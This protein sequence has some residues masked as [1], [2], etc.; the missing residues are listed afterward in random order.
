MMIKEFIVTLY[1]VMY[2]RQLKT[3]YSSVS[4]ACFTTSLFF[5][6]LIMEGVVLKEI[7]SHTRVI[8][9]QPRIMGP[10][11]FSILSFIIYLMLF[12]VFKVEPA[13]D[14]GYSISKETT[15]KIWI[16]YII[17]ILLFFILPVVRKVIFKL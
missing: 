7:V 10:I 1:K 3:R 4:M 6:F 12:K 14:F 13:S 9:G 17:N 11:Y 16:I 2:N 8:M 15:R 5:G